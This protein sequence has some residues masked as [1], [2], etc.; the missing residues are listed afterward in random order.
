MGFVFHVGP[1][2]DDTE[3][4]LAQEDA[5][6]NWAFVECLR[7]NSDA[8][9]DRGR[10]W[11]L[12]RYEHMATMRN[13]LLDFAISR[14]PEFYFSC[15]TDMLLPRKTLEVLRRDIHNYDG[16]APMT[17]MT[18][19]GGGTAITN[20]M[21]RTGERCPAWTPDVRRVYACFGAVLMTPALMAVRYKAHGQGEDLGWAENVQE[22]GL[23]LAI[24]PHVRVKHVMHPDHLELRD[25]RVGF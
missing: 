9:L 11:N 1:S 21:E 15:D 4:I 25:D 23:R 6:G 2:A 18:P 3:K 14:G 19:V 10:N 8:H 16:I 17:F 22:A 20:A 5:W 13:E 24:T 7:D 12:T